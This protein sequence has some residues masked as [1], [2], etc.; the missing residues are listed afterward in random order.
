M[1]K[2]HGTWEVGLCDGGF[3]NVGMKENCWLFVSRVTWNWCTGERLSDVWLSMIFE[4]NK[5]K[6]GHLQEMLSSYSLSSEGQPAMVVMHTLWF[7]KVRSW[8]LVF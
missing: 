7:S 5:A 2:E 6:L 1:D 3:G 8:N 4:E